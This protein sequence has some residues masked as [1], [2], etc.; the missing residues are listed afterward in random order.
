VPR[1]TPY[2]VLVVTAIVALAFVG[3]FLRPFRIPTSSMVPTFRPGDQVLAARVY[4]LTGP[5]RGDLVVFHPNGKG[6]RVFF[7]NTASSETYVKRL[8]GMPGE[9]IGSHAGRVYICRKGSQPPAAGAPDGTPGCAYLRESYVHGQA[10]G[11]CGAAGGDFGPI[12]IGP[13][14]YYFLGDNRLGSEDSR[15]FGQVAR[16][17]LIGEVFFTYWPPHRWGIP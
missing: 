11:P 10:T 9:L 1:I 12:S 8:I 7:T 5:E 2:R 16:D 3:W 15:C 14:S 4:T 13:K 17:Q 6:S